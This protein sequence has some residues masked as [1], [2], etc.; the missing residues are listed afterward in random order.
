VSEPDRLRAHVYEVLFGCAAVAAALVCASAAAAEVGYP[1]KPIRLI[2]ASSPG[3]PND[4]AARAFSTPWSEALGRPI[5]IDN[6]AGAAGVIGT[7]LGAKAP[8]DGYTLLLGFQGPLVI[9]PNLSDSIPY[10]TLKDFA[11]VSLAVSA[12]FV[13]LVHPGVPARSVKDLIALARERPGK[14]NYA[15]GGVGIGSHMAMELLKHITAIDVIHVPYKGAGPGMTALVAGEVSMMFASVGAALPH[16]KAER[17]RALAIGGDQRSAVLP[18]L[19]T[20]H[21]SG[22]GVSATSWYGVLVPGQTP[23]SV[24][25]RVHDTLVVVLEAPATRTRL[26]QLGFDVNASTAQAFAKVIRE[27]LGLWRNVIATAGLKGK[28]Q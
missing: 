11:P 9:A 27:E 14:L 7:E 2:V 6:R 19:P 13:L 17:L 24:I 28:I 22:Y 26:T 1:T 3:G 21:E 20:L 25:S 8:P 15:S 5:V 18:D 10:D 4:V 23:R 16:V 12:P